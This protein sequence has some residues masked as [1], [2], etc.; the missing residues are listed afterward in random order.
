M[1]TQ[2]IRLSSVAEAA[3]VGDVLAEAFDDSPWIR[4][5][6]GEGRRRERL[7]ALY[8]WQAGL[9]G[10]EQHGTWVAEEDGEVVAAACWSRPDAAPLSAATAELLAR[11]M[12]PLLGDRAAAVEEAEAASAALR[13]VQPHWLLGCVGT[14]PRWRGRGIAS[15]LLAAGI[16][17]LDAQGLPAV[18]ETSAPAN[19]RLYQRLGF[20]VRAELD[21]PGGAPHVWVMQRPSQPT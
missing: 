2:T 20:T 15:A 3:T 4:W 16:R 6:L 5:A 14:R 18:L 10:A 13:P 11:E 1:T 17:E 8:R 21:P 9:A 12:P 19:V 7:T